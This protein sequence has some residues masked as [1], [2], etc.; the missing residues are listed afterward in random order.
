MFATSL[1]FFMY[2]FNMQFVVSILFAAKKSQDE[3]SMD[4]DPGKKQFN[5]H[6]F[7]LD[8]L[9]FTFADNIMVAYLNA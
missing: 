8:I 3:C 4:L 1:T 2:I 9:R 5:F 7:Y 6:S